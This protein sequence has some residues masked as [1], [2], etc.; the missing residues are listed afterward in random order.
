MSS[1]YDWSRIGVSQPSAD[2]QECNLLIVSGWLNKDLIE[3]V[4]TAYAELS[5]RRLVIAVGACAISGGPFAR[6]DQKVTK[7]S[8]VIPVDVYVPGCPPRPEA[9]IDAVRILKTKM[10]PKSDQKKVLYEAL[11]SQSSGIEY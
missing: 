11:R 6:G 2:P 1:T 4:R 7:L 9:L 10:G 3:E 8:D 5:G